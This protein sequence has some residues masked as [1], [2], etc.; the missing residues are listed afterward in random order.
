M[1][2]L[3]L[4]QRFSQQPQN[5]NQVSPALKADFVWSA[6]VGAI[7]TP[8]PITRGSSVGRNRSGTFIYSGYDYV[9]GKIVSNHSTTWTQIGVAILDG[10]NNTYPI[11]S[12]SSGQQ[13]IL[14]PGQIDCIMWGVVSVPITGTLPTG[15]VNYVVSRNG[16]THTAWLNGKLFG[17]ATDANTPGG[18]IGNDTAIGAQGGPIGGFNGIQPL[19]TG[20]GLYMTVKTVLCLPDA[21]CLELSRNPWQVFNDAAGTKRWLDAIAAA[22]GGTVPYRRALTGVGY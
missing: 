19:Q 7:K 16:S 15:I 6:A 18:Y 12:R 14:Q 1:P 10:V 20:T 21:Y 3:I 4:P 13:I 9:S 17:T 2:T 11:S 8:S 5:A 22:P